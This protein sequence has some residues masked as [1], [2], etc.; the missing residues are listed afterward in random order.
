MYHKTFDNTIIPMKYDSIRYIDQNKDAT[1]C[2]IMYSYK[3][4]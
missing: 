3:W 1:I 4:P 2:G